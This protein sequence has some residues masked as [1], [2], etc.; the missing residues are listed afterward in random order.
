MS[1]VTDHH[2]FGDM[3]ERLNDYV[4]ANLRFRVNI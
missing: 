1:A 3:N 4:L 2:V